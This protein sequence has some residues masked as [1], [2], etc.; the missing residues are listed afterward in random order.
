MKKLIS[1]NVETFWYVIWEDTTSSQ[2]GCSMYGS[3]RNIF[4]FKEAFEV[5]KRSLASDS[6]PLIK[7]WKRITSQQFEEFLFYFDK[8][9]SNNKKMKN[10]N[11]KVI[12]GGKMECRICKKC[13]KIIKD[14]E[15]CVQNGDNAYLCMECFEKS[16]KEVTILD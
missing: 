13:N 3:T 1:L 15:P 9:E 4:S 16:E 11:L 6:K 7:D 14:E 8:I 2:V 12:R 5:I 10:N